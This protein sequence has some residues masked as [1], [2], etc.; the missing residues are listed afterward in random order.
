MKLDSKSCNIFCIR[1]RFGYVLCKRIQ[2]QKQYGLSHLIGPVWVPACQRSDPY[3]NPDQ[4]HDATKRTN[5]VIQSQCNDNEWFSFLTKED[6]IEQRRRKILAV[7]HSQFTNSFDIRIR[8]R[9]SIIGRRMWAIRSIYLPTN[10]WPLYP[11]R[12]L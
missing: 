3:P 5:L 8:S 9:S 6:E 1:T 4:R 12:S 2:I 11:T 7:C 10:P